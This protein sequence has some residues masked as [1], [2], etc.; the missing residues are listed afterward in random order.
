M[1]NEETGLAVGVNLQKNKSIISGS[2]NSTQL[3]LPHVTSSTQY[4]LPHVTSKSQCH[5]IQICT[6]SA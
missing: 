1:E 6:Q 4:F 3:F 5:S 2:D